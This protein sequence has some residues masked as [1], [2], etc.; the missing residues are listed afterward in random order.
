ME[1]GGLPSR[2]RRRLDTVCSLIRIDCQVANVWGEETRVRG[3]RVA[4]GWP[5]GLDTRQRV[6]AISP[7]TGKR[8]VESRRSVQM[9]RKEENAR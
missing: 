7:A 4:K 5:V 8:R 3:C 1:A 2:G 6:E 9:A